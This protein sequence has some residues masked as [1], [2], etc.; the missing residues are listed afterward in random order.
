[1]KQYLIWDEGC[2]SKESVDSFSNSWKKPALFRE[3]V[4]TF[5]VEEINP[6]TRSPF[7]Y[8]S[9]VHENTHLSQ[10][11]NGLKAT[12]FGVSSVEVA[13]AAARACR[14]FVEG[15][16]VAVLEHAAVCVPVSGFH[17]A[18]WDY[19]EGYC[20]FNGLMAAVAELDRMNKRS[21]I[22]DCDA[23]YGD[24]T[25]DI[26]AKCGFDDSVGHWTYG[27]SNYAAQGQGAKFL[28]ALPKI[29]ERSK[30][31]DVVL[32]Q[33]G[34]D[35]H[36]DDPLGGYLTTEQMRERDRIVFQFCAENDKPVVWNLAGG[37]QTPFDKVLDLHMNTY[38]EWQKIFC[39]QLQK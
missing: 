23:H 22:L 35:P 7:D 5:G 24:G 17:H 37:Y 4:S 21:F 34:A 33:A 10:V 11:L 39:N 14:M 32:Y 1:M 26:I 18:G 38:E 6:V 12:G 29:L 2:I 20:T 8:L 19:S 13:W 28:K 16:R 36:V 9:R 25:D 15:A 30:K 3:K 31:Y 27:E